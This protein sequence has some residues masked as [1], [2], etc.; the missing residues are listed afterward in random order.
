MPAT[1]CQ[2]AFNQSMLIGECPLWQ[3]DQAALY[4]V[5][6]AGKAVH[7][8]HP[9]SGMH[10]SW[11]MPSEPAAIAHCASGGLMVALR[12]GFSHLDTNSGSIRPIA[13]ATYDTAT[14]RFN[15]G[16]CD[17]AGRFWAGTMY[18]PRDK[19]NAAMYC[20]ER[21]N[22]RTAWHGGITVSNGLA[23]SPDNR[24]MYHADTTAHAIYRRDFD[25]ATG[26][27]GQPS[28]FKQFSSNRTE[29][30]GGRPDGAAVDSEGAYWCAMF[31]GGRLLR[32]APDGMILSEITLPLRCPTMLAFG[33][34]DLRTLYVTSAS[35]NRSQEELEQF[36][37][38]GC[39]LCLRVD[40]AGRIE[41][42]YM[43]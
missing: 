27:A 5:D 39:I 36:P 4:W 34:D 30:Y 37:L 15:D 7:R 13:S 11:Q 1:T 24:I 26:H 28:I 18:E 10:R 2:I 40:V 12:S 19:K 22:V 8:L 38:S 16:R 23:F 35:N 21:G 3:P 25:L 32:L 14:T 6:I 33:G 31:D 20:L 43:E 17:A 29:G 42:A 9:A 41:P